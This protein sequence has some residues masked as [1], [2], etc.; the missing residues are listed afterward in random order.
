[1]EALYDNTPVGLAVIDG[2]RKFVRVNQEFA[3]IY[4]LSAEACVGRRAWDVVPGRE[5]A[6]EPKIV[7]VLETG[8]AVEL[9]LSWEIG[10]QPGE[11]RFW[12]KK[13]YPIRAASGLVT[14]VGLVVEDVT[15]RKRSEEHL[16]FL[17]REIS[18]RSKNLLAVIQAMANQT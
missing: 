13:L 10:R 4:G 6:L 7:E 17:L 14:A 12:Q 18:H 8:R 15:E 1:I 2:D 3:E 16:R 5:P 11:P 9:E